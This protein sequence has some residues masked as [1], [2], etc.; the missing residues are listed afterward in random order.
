MK[1]RRTLIEGGFIEHLSPSRFIVGASQIFSFSGYIGCRS[2]LFFALCELIKWRL[3]TRRDPKHR[4]KSKLSMTLTAISV[5]VLVVDTVDCSVFHGVTVM[6][7]TEPSSQASKRDCFDHAL[8]LA[9][10]NFLVANQ[11]LPSQ[12]RDGQA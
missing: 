10:L 4:V 5:G 3:S 12:I 9:I 6:R 1:I 11:K 2:P 7:F 8:G